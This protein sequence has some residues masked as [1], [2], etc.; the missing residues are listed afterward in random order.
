MLHCRVLCHV[1]SCCT[2]GASEWLW[3][4][5]WKSNIYKDTC[6]DKWLF[7]ITSY[8]SQQDSF[9]SVFSCAQKKWNMCDENYYRVTFFLQQLSISSCRNVQVITDTAGNQSFIIHRSSLDMNIAKTRL[10]VRAYT[11]HTWRETGFFGYTNDIWSLLCLRRS[12]DTSHQGNPCVWR[13]PIELYK[14]HSSVSRD[15]GLLLKTV[16]FHHKP[17][18]LTCVTLN[19]KFKLLLCVRACAC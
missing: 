1:S 18:H 4:R 15:C 5:H 14:Q 2:T 6:G 9:Y 7:N 16:I 12:G 11:V 10:L 17:G 3:S 8:K 13:W 19:F